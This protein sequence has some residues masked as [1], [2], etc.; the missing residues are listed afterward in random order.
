MIK[1]N[2]S[3]AWKLAVTIGPLVA[4]ALALA[5]GIKWR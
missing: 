1:H 3:R 2:V 5:A 4:I